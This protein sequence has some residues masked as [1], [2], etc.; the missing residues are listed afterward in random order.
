MLEKEF[1]DRLRINYET[2]V[3]RL[4]NQRIEVSFELARCL[5]LETRTNPE[6]NHAIG[7]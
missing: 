3:G 1:G 6:G 2:T 5:W 4:S 7:V